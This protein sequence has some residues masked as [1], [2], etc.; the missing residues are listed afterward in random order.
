MFQDGIIRKEDV[1]LGGN[2]TRPSNICE[3]DVSSVQYLQ[4]AYKSITI[5]ISQVQG[6]ASRLGR[7]IDLNNESLFDTASYMIIAH[8]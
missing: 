5:K 4:G 8:E 2:I 7:F 6:P 1:I 3:A